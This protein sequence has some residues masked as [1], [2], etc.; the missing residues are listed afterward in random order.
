MSDEF[1]EVERERRINRDTI[2]ERES[3]LENGDRGRYQK[4]E[5]NIL[6]KRMDKMIEGGL[7]REKEGKRGSLRN[8]M[9][10]EET[11][12]REDVRE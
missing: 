5:K 12:K 1:R 10:R 7:W 8:G 3:K 2:V 4:R 6:G 11:N 9:R